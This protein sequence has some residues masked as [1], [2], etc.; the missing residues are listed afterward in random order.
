MSVCKTSIP[1]PP[2]PRSS[3]RSL[4][5]NK[6]K[7]ASIRQSLVQENEVLSAVAGNRDTARSLAQAIEN[8]SPSIL[9]QTEMALQSIDAKLLEQHQNRLTAL[10]SKFTGVVT[11][12]W[13]LKH[14]QQ[15]EVEIELDFELGLGRSFEERARARQDVLQA[16]QEL[17]QVEAELEEACAP[18]RT[19]ALRKFDEATVTALFDNAAARFALEFWQGR[20]RKLLPSVQGEAAKLLAEAQ[21]KRWG[22]EMDQA[23]EVARLWGDRDAYR[24]APRIYKT[25]QV[26]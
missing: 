4:R 8:L 12:R 24:A 26:S 11:A 21:A 16:E 23:T 15:V 19:E 6:K 7:I 18:V 25:R 1:R 9:Y 10:K 17:A 3:A 14:V 22:E 20:L 5:P 2:L 13:R